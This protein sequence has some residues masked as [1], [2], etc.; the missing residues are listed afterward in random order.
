[1]RVI[2]TFLGVKLPGIKSRLMR[3]GQFIPC[4]ALLALGWGASSLG[5]TAPSVGASQTL[6]GQEDT[7]YL[8]RPSKYSGLP[9][10]GEFQRGE[11]ESAPD[12]DR[13]QIREQRYADTNYPRPLVVDPGVLINGQKETTSL[14]FIDYVISGKF[15]DPRGIPVSVSTA[16][17]VGTV[18]NGKCFVTKSH[19][20]VYTDYLVR[21]DQVL[22]QDPT[23]NLSIGDV[24]VAAREGGA[25]R[26]PSG[27]MTNYLTAGHGLPQI[28]SQYVLFLSKSIQG[29]PEY[30]IMFDA[31]YQLQNGR[32]YPLDD[33]N[34]QYVGVDAYVFLDEVQKAIAASKK[35][36]ARQ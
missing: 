15:I 29:F 26:F 16:V 27:H 18:T 20:Y 30:E 14:T 25:I 36:G 35:R 6:P 5:Q 11:L 17:V 28:G 1:M 3:H 8:K 2:V 19:T 33:V 9:L 34:S 22:K 13:R 4:A 32:V 24:V 21:I 31:G 7:G 12:S 10:V 23:A